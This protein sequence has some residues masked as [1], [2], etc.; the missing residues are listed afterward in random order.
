MYILSLPELFCLISADLNDKEKIFLISCSKK[1]H[2]FKSL[3]TLDSEY[4]LEEISDRYCTKN[5]IIK[6]FTLENK[7]KEL[8]ENLV[9]ESIIVNYKYVKF[10]SNNMNIKLFYDEEIIEKI[11]SYGCSYLAMKI[12]LNNDDSIDNIT[13]Q[14]INASMYGHLS[15]VKLKMFQICFK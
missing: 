14:F 15:I 13:N 4:D 11:I 9:P 2:S 5:I 7:I 3:L 12:I 1:V 10:V 8:I 6:E